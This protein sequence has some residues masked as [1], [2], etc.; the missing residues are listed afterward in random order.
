M[1]SCHCP[2]S[3][4]TTLNQPSILPYITPHMTDIAPDA[5]KVIEWRQQMPAAQRD[6]ARFLP[7]VLFF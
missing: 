5:M 6:S 4:V 3:R 2:A 1:S 7:A